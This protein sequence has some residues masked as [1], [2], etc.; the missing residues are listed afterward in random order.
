MI[1][2]GTTT[3]PKVYSYTDRKVNTGNYIYRL[4]QIDFNGTYE[5]SDEISVEVYN[6][7][8]YLLHQNY[9]N[10]FN[11]STIITYEIPENSFVSLKVYDLLGREVVSLVNEEKSAGRYDV[12]FEASDNNSGLYVYILKA[13][14]FTSTK[15]MLLL[16]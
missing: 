11:P 12:T 14:N 3:E 5:Y 16:K 13:G 2:V 7:G 6:P 15:K 4:K 8:N 1:M 10:P 9:P